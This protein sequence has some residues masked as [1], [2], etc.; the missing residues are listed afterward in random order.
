MNRFYLAQLCTIAA[1]FAVP[2]M[3]Q[4]MPV[5]Q[6]V[7]AWDRGD[8]SRAV[9]LWSA[10]AEKGD[11]D[12]QFNLAQAYKLGR[13]ITAD[14]KQAELWYGKAAQQGHEQGEASYG[15]ALFANGKQQDAVRWL[16]RAAHRGDP[17]AQYLLG[18][19]HFNG[20]FVARD[21]PR[22]YAL[23]TRASQT[24]L[25]EASAAVAQMDQHIPLAQ[26]QEGLKL[27]R[28]YEVAFN[29]APAPLP[30][31]AVAEAPA[32][33]SSKPQTSS[34]S[35]PTPQ[36][37]ISTKP[38]AAAP[39]AAAVKPAA[40]RPK[41][42][43]D[44]GWRIQL[45]SFADAKNAASLWGKVRGKLPGRSVSYVKAGNFTRVLVG[46]FASQREATEHCR[47]LNPCVPVRK[48]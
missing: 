20:D 14:L 46:P 32:A 3:A 13:G 21:W 5:K 27:A 9:T 40:P 29:R 44:G 12:A 28:Q 25:A 11:A 1:C 36:Q 19:M 42:I 8:Y 23:A 38:A 45:G 35:P 4:D 48:P 2:A 17:R 7:D 18:T 33:T 6:G 24:G 22:A 31:Q 15:L 26:R 30:V 39:V 10:E 43:T 37:A 47:G 34:A 16:E 41:P